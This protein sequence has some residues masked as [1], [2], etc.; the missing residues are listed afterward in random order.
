MAEATV[1]SSVRIEDAAPPYVVAVDIGSGSTRCSLYDSLARPVKKHTHKADHAFLE[2]ADGTVEIDADQVVMEVESVVTKATRGLGRGEVLAFVM[3]T[4][5]SSFIAVDRQG[6]ALTACITYADSRSAPQLARLREV[7]DEDEV[8]HRVGARLHTSYHPPRLLWLA[9][10]YPEVAAKTD[11][12]LSLGEY[13]YLK[14]AGISGAAT[15]T[16]AWAGILNRTTGELDAELLDAV[17][18][19][20]DRFA[21]I[22]DP[23]KPIREVSPRVAK[24]WPALEGAAWFPAIPDGYASNLGVGATGPQTVALSAATSGAMRTI[25]YGAPADLPSGLWSYRV[26]KD[27]SIVGGALNDVGRVTLWLEA[28]LAPI[29]VAQVNELL[30]EPPSPATPLMLPFLTGERS[31][32]WAGSARGVITGL[33]SSCGTRC[34]WRG[35]LEGVALSYARVFRQLQEV[36]PQVERIIGSGGVLG[37]Y[38]HLMDVTSGAVNSPVRIVDAK[39]VTMRGAAVLALSVLRP[40]SLLAAPPLTA[41]ILPK[42]D[43]QAYYTK[44]LE[45]F[46]WTYQQVI[47]SSPPA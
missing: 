10:E 17:G 24:R 35:A 43:Q 38:P 40:G 25:V 47:A 30:Q 36:N 27:Q 37:R 26:S 2:A 41:S 8:H 33:S 11:T 9:E 46:E 19:E 3:D 28:T 34:L 29:S 45:E 42:P 18:V 20:P 44:R 4:F 7:M 1:L 32:G 6:N 16:M 23:D 22:V 21:G 12:Y 5:A 14:M 15:S 13:V 39:R 31:T